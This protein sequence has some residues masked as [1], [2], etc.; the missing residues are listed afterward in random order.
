MGRSDGSHPS[1]RYLNEVQVILVDVLSSPVSFIPYLSSHISGSTSG[2]KSL[3]GHHPRSQHERASSRIRRRHLCMGRGNGGHRGGRGRACDDGGQ[4][5]LRLDETG[6]G[7]RIRN[8]VSISGQI[9]AESPPAYER[10]LDR[11]PYHLVIIL[12]GL[13]LSGSFYNAHASINKEELQ[14]FSRRTGTRN[15]HFEQILG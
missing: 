5:S 11:S 10:R 14:L 4:G 12:L 8:G 3:E 9:E 15:V 6:A 1:P 2:P 13:I 7:T